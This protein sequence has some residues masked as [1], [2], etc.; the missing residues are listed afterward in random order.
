M[1][2]LVTISLFCLGLLIL[3]LVWMTQ[4]DVTLYNPKGLIAEQQFKLM[5]FSTAVLLAVAVPTIGLLYSFA[6]KYR[7]SN[8]KAKRDLTKRRGGLFAVSLWIIP[9]LVLVIL[10]SVVIPTTYKLD[11]HEAIA[12]D[13]KPLVIQVIALR[14]KWV[15]IYPEQRISTVNY[16]QVPVDRPIQFNLTADEAP[17]NSFWIPHWGGQ[18][19]AMTA[20]DNRLNLMADTTGDFTGRAAEINGEGFSGMQFQARASSNSEFDQWVNRVR[21]S[22]KSLT[23]FEYS[24]LV[25]PSENNRPTFYAATDPNIYKTVLAKYSASHHGHG[26]VE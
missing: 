8:P 17:M 2:K 7:E 6:W 1:V 9:I 5:M 18:L 26:G 16:V 3:A 23:S 14:W 15:F 4:A 24:K 25:L 10:A 21:Q 22:P 12:S 19:Y 11:P 13:K 20:H